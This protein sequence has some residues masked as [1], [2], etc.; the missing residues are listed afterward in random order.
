M[1]RITSCLSANIFCDKSDCHK[2]SHAEGE[3]CEKADRVNL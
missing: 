2:E 3:N 1:I